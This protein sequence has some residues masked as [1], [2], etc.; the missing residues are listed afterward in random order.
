MSDTRAL[1]AAALLAAGCATTGTPPPASHAADSGIT[2]PAL[3]VE[4]PPVVDGVVNE[5]A[6]RD[7]PEIE[8]PLESGEGPDACRLRAAVH[9]G[10]LYLLVR[11]RDATGDREHEP[12]VPSED[13]KWTQGPER[14]DELAVA[15]PMEGPFTADMTSPVEALWDVW[16]WKS[17]RTDP[18]GHA[19]DMTHRMTLSDPGGKRKAHTLPD[20]SIL[21]MTRTEDAGSSATKTLEAPASGERAPQYR[22]VIPTGSAGDV[23]ARGRWQDGWW[24]VE[25]ARALSTGEGDDRDFSAR[26]RIPFALAI[27]DRAEN[28]AQSLSTVL[29]LEIPPARGR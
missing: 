17:A 16:H 29:V 1:L 10:S 13:G 8:I 12:W 19:M 5:Q 4:E 2:L 15:F 23:L 11:W 25:L 28:E 3:R 27:L 7:A 6:W 22:A 20:G 14:E 26:G 24:T 21:Y 9:G 18:A